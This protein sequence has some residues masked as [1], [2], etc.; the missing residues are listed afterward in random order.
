M[1]AKKKPAKKVKTLGTKK[2][3]REKAKDVKGG[4]VWQPQKKW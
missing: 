3:A 1:A 4:L 2:L